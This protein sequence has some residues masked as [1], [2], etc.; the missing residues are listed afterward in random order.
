MLLSK[1]HRA[2]SHYSHFQPYTLDTNPRSNSGQLF[3]LSSLASSHKFAGHCEQHVGRPCF[4]CHGLRTFVTLVSSEAACRHR[5]W[6][7][8]P[9][10]ALL[11]EL[12]VLHGQVQSKLNRGILRAKKDALHENPD[13]AIQSTGLRCGFYFRDVH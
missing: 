5:S 9:S 12:P 2:P 10:L 11:S 6:C 3:K 7:F 13:R 4:A 8:S 1:K